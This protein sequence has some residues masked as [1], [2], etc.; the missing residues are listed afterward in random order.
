MLH[1][2]RS[3]ENAFNWGGYDPHEKDDV[4][5]MTL[6]SEFADLITRMGANISIPKSNRSIDSSE[7]VGAISDWVTSGKRAVL[8]INSR[9]YRNQD[10]GD[11]MDGW[12]SRNYGRHFVV[13][14][15]LAQTESGGVS[16]KYWDL[17]EWK[18]KTK[19]FESFDEF[20]KSS[21]SYWL[22]KNEGQK[23][24]QNE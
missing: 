19:Q 2:L 20:K 15:G 22:I 21:F 16:V 1:S 7:D 8:F 11:G 24:N 13:I 5:K 6:K 18:L 9:A 23:S 10:S 12:I 4:S 3:S 14:K 17:G